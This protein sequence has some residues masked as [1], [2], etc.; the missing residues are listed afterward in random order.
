MH[1]IVVGRKDIGTKPVLV[2]LHGYAATGALYQS[3]FKQLS[4][5][6]VVI[7]CD[8]IGMGLSSRHE[9]YF[10]KDMTPEEAISFFVEHFEKW[11]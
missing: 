11:R 3:L 4:E 7:T 5:H 8:H 2:F 10:N 1:S 9:G 6:F